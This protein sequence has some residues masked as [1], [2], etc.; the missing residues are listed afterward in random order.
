MYRTATRSPKWHWTIPRNSTLR[1]NPAVRRLSAV[2]VVGRRSGP[3]KLAMT[4]SLGWPGCGPSCRRFKISYR[5]RALIS[6]GALSWPLYL[7][8]RS[9]RTVARRVRNVPFSAVSLFAMKVRN[10]LI[11]T[12]AAEWLNGC[13][14]AQRAR[15]RSGPKQRSIEGRSIGTAAHYRQKSECLLFQIASQQAI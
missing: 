6:C 5:R 10:E 13:E 4:E 14:R 12:N 9:L 8:K 15:F 1:P 2:N 3:S 11:L 7:R